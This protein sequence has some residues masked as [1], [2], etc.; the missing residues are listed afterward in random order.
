MEAFLLCSVTTASWFR[1]MSKSLVVLS[2]LVILALSLSLILPA[3]ADGIVNGGFETGDFTGW[4]VETCNDYTGIMGTAYTKSCSPIGETRNAVVG[5]GTDPDIP[6]STVHDGNYAAKIG[7]N[8]DEFESVIGGS[9]APSQIHWESSIT[10]TAT[11]PAPPATFL[12]FWYAIGAMGSHPQNIAAG[13]VLTVVAGSTTVFTAENRAYT[14]PSN[15]PGWIWCDG[16]TCALGLAYYP[17]TLV[18]VDLSAY[19][20]QSLT[21]TLLLHGCGQTA[22]TAWGYLDN[23]IIDLPH[24]VTTS[25]VTSTITSATTTTTT[26]SAATA[27]TS[28]IGMSSTTFTS[29]STTTAGGTVTEYV[30]VNNVVYLYLLELVTVAIAVVISEYPLGLALLA[31]FMV[32]GYGLIKR[33]TRHPKSI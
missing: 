21:I 15:A 14:S 24:V 32:I 12:S 3:Y 20:G 25:T 27:T 33:R 13:F 17:W 28:T 9:Q 1:S 2:C 11:V 31:I 19:A 29:Y 18:S 6:V 10:Q 23:I 22:H 30:L 26:G 5:I 4:T 7:Y 16:T 8:Y